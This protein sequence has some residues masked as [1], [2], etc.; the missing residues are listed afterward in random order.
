VL[1]SDGIQTTMAESEVFQVARK[2]PALSLSGVTDG[3]V[4]LPGTVLA[5]RADYLDVDGD[6]LDDADFVW[7]SDAAGV[8]GVGAQLDVAASALPAGQQIIS[9]TIPGKLGPPVFRSAT[10]LRAPQLGEVACRGD[11]D[12]NGVV[13]INE[14]VRAVGIALGEATLAVCPVMDADGSGSVTIN[15]LIAA[16]GRALN[17]C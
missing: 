1:A 9:V 17:G 12:L 2:E 16:V 8:L 6:V 13:A 11:C 14:L 7:R 4:V 10:I 3:Q 5:L 15:E